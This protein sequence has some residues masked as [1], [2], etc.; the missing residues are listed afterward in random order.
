MYYIIYVFFFPVFP[1][2]LSGIPL[3]GHR[4]DKRRG[5][6]T[7][8]ITVT[9]DLKSRRPPSHRSVLCNSRP[10]Y[11]RRRRLH[12]PPGPQTPVLTTRRE[13]PL[14]HR[15]RLLLFITI[16][17]IINSS[18]HKVRVITFKYHEDDDNNQTYIYCKRRRSVSSNQLRLSRNIREYEI[19][20]VYRYKKCILFDNNS[21]MINPT[22]F[23]LTIAIFLTNTGEMTTRTD[24]SVM[25]SKLVT[26]T[27]CSS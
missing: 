7:E 5:G 21:R 23:S 11:P 10:V 12:A 27:N 2:T 6:K 18:F 9:S 24:V 14:G 17:I 1:S 19:T 15:V 8:K 22:S 25:N 26:R 4:W 20:I 3:S 16:V 13:H